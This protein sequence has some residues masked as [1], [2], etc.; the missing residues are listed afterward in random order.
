MSI[1]IIRFGKQTD[2]I[3]GFLRVL[4]ASL[5]QLAEEKG[6]YRKYRRSYDRAVPSAAMAGSLHTMHTV[7]VD[8][9]S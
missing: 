6:S 3:S 2:F 9:F 1:K 7:V 8:T 5:L 4:R